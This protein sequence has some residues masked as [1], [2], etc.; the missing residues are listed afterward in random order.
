[1]FKHFARKPKCNKHFKMGQQPCAITIF[2]YPIVY[3]VLVP[4]LGW[5]LKI[6][7]WNSSYSKP[8]PINSPPPPKREY[9]YV[10]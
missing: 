3:D 8:Y 10:R 6:P 4:K 5:Q 7:S 2:S 1:M 9:N